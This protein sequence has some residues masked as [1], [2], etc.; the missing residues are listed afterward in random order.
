MRIPQILAAALCLSLCA[1]AAAR[2]IPAE[3][4]RALRDQIKKEH[5]ISVRKLVEKGGKC[6]LSFP[7]GRDERGKVG[8]ALA[9]HL[10]FVTV[11]KVDVDG[12]KSLKLKLDRNFVMPETKPAP[13]HPGSS[14][15]K[16]ARGEKDSGGRGGARPPAADRGR[17]G[18]GGRGGAGGR[19]GG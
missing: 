12:V 3:S 11:K 15:G 6:T 1:T 18:E 16:D 19:D 5:L 10:S 9:A 8:E 17:P 14:A 7:G 2:S 13:Q 4:F